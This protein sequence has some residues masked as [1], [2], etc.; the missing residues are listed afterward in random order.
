MDALISIY[1]KEKKKV[2]LKL[3]SMYQKNKN[4]K[5]AFNVSK[6]KMVVFR[7]F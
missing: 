3:L 2:K 6:M 7:M 1:Q 4:K 5:A